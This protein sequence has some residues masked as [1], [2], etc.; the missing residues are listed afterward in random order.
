MINLKDNSKGRMCTQ[1][2]SYMVIYHS[3]L[4]SMILNWCKFDAVINLLSSFGTPKL[5][6]I[7]AKFR[8]FLR[9]FGKIFYAKWH[10]KNKN[11]FPP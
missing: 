10:V 3:I 9:F 11:I 8:Q 6:S 7:E 1:Q 2:M 5:D 4:N